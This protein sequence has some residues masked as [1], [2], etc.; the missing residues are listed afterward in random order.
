MLFYVIKGIR[1][2]SVLLASLKKQIKL[3]FATSNTNVAHPFDIIHSDLWTSPI[4]S[5]SGIKYYV[6]FLDHHSHFLWVYPMRYKHETFSKYL[7][8]ANYVKTQFGKDIKSLQCDNGGEFNNSQFHDFFA[9]KGTTFRFSCPHTSQQNGKSER[10]IRTIN[11]AIRCLLFQARLPPS[12]W[13]EALHTAVHILNLLPSK[14]I[15]NKVPFSVL[16]KKPISYTHLK[17]FGCLCYPNIN[18]S[19]AHKLSPRSTKCLFIGYPSDH[20]GYR[21]LDLT[22]N[23]IILSRHVAFDETQFPYQDSKAQKASTYDFLSTET[24]PSPLLRSILE[25]PMAPSN[26]VTPPVPQDAPTP[27]A[28][29]AVEPPKHPMSTRSKHGITKPKQIFLFLLSLSLLFQKAIYKP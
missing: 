29:P 15:Q 2:N 14:A 22:T 25:T 18:H 11:N 7:H 28:P 21:C 27:P 3:P 17:T 13:V 9:E 26:P 5:V 10:M 19:N 24:D 23:K 8:F 1:L 20:R 16:F 12:Y 4:Q 6:L